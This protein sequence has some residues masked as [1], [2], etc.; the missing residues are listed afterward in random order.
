MSYIWYLAVT[1]LLA[2]IFALLILRAS[3]ITI[4]PEYKYLAGA[5]GI[6]G[7]TFAVLGDGIFVTD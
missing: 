6:A 4:E 2:T 7:F 5:I 3:N 1:I